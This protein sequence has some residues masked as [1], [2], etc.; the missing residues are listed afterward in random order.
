MQEQLNDSHE[1]EEDEEED[2][3]TL[4]E[5]VIP[6]LGPD[7]PCRMLLTGEER[8]AA[9][10]IKQLIEADP[11]LDNLNDF[12]YAQLALMIDLDYQDLDET[13]LLPKLLDRARKL[14]VIRQEY[15][16]VETFEHAQQVVHRAVDLYGD[17]F[18]SYSY[19]CLLYTSPSPR[20]QRGSRMPS[21][22]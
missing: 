19:S 8:D 16:I 9:L 4:L 7:D 5:N 11:E 21:S 10:L 14:Q 15:S 22:A 3:A 18:L 1:T 2:E 13:E 17:H 12:Q 6:R 20:D